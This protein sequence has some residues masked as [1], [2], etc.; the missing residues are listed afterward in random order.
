MSIFT[1]LLIAL[2]LSFDSFAVS[3]CSGLSMCRKSLKL[4]QTLRIAGSLAVFQAGMPL[5]GWLVGNTFNNIV[6]Q[7]D[8]W[9]AFG[10]LLIL[11]LK[12]IKEGTVPAHEKKIKNPARWRVLIPLSVATSIDAFVI[13]ISFSFFSNQI[14]LPVILIGV[15]T[16]TVSLVGIYMGRKIGKRLSGIAEIIGG[17]TLI[18]I[19]LKF[20]LDEYLFAE[21][22]LS[23]F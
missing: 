6:E 18:L 14:T 1:I 15:V 17:I 5:L 19:G 10:L 16:F 4:S 22:L 11:G 23:I 3:V 2:S 8:H 13:G 20:I 9:I 7:Y 21:P 12:M